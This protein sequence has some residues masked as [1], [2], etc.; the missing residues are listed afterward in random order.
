MTDW[1]WLFAVCSAFCVSGSHHSVVSLARSRTFL[2]PG[3]QHQ[4]RLHSQSV[5]VISPDFQEHIVTFFLT[6]FHANFRVAAW[7]VNF[8]NGKT[9]FSLAWCRTFSPP[10]AQHQSRISTQRY[11]YIRGKQCFTLILQRDIIFTNNV[12]LNSNSVGKDQNR[13]RQE[14]L[15]TVS[16]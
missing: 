8:I 1:S 9:N 3:A 12:F 11:Y 5:L 14:P 15:H 13:S 10:G 4:S 16:I 2:P 6:F 7:Y